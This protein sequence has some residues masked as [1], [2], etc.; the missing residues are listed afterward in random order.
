MVK[1]RKTNFGRTKQS[2]GFSTRDPLFFFAAR[3]G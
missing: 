3:K 2:K 1:K